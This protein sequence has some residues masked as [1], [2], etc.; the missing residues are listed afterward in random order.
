MSASVAPNCEESEREEREKSEKGERERGVRDSSF[1]MNQQDQT[2]LFKKK[3]KSFPE[4][5]R[6]VHCEKEKKSLRLLK[7]LNGTAKTKQK[8]AIPRQGLHFG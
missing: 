6:N 7:Y 3:K 1:F 8:S 4:M 5:D 2:P